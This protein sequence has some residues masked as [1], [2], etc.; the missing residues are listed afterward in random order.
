[1]TWVQK[2]SLS[3]I[4]INGG[5]HGIALNKARIEEG[6]RK[7]VVVSLQCSVFR[8]YVFQGK[9]RRRRRQTCSS[10]CCTKKTSFLSERESAPLKSLQLCKI[11]PFCWEFFIR[12]PSTTSTQK[13]THTASHIIT[14]CI[15]KCM[16]YCQNIFHSVKRRVHLLACFL[17]IWQLRPRYFVLAGFRVLAL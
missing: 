15:I 13:S 12:Y 9:K 3:Q 1:M 5:K 11:W 14:Y 16:H 17:G 7:L 10:R 2:G 6:I 8:C 4:Q